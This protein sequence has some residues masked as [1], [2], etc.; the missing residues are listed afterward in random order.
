MRQ[1][2]NQG[3]AV[4]THRLPITGA[5]GSTGTFLGFANP[6][7]TTA[8]IHNRF[9]R[10]TTVATGAATVD[11]GVAA[12]GTTAS[13]TLLDGQDVNAATG[14]FVATGVNGAAAREWGPTQFIT[15]TE[16]SGD[17]N[18]LVAELIVEVSLL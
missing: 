4:I 14:L 11:I 17:V 12:N 15:V 10:V 8:I 6:F 7:G 18:G 1:A 5:S 3:S 9:L 13:D 2:G 16:A